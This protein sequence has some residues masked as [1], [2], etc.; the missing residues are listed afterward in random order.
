MVGDGQRWLAQFL[1]PLAEHVNSAAA[2]EEAEV[3]MHVQVHEGVVAG[4]A[5]KSRQ[6]PGGA[7]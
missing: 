7:R 3:G 4:H 2:I 6:R 1:G 5:Q